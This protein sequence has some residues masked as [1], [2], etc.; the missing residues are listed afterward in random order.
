MSNDRRIDAE[1]GK[2]EVAKNLELIAVLERC[3]AW[4]GYF[5]RRLAR[6]RDELAA[7]VLDDDTL[8]PE[9]RERVRAAYKA[10]R[11]LPAMVGQD[12]AGAER[13]LAL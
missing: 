10:I 9:D 13:A 6:R 12:K 8:T 5:L 3:P 4:E 1:G 2:E 7:T 11:D